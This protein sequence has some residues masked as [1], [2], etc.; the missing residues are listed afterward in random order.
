MRKK[1]N[2]KLKETQKNNGI[3]DDRISIGE[4]RKIWDDDD[5]KYTDKELLKIRG[6]FYVLAEV[7]LKIYYDPN[8]EKLINGYKKWKH[9]RKESNIVC[10]GEYRRAS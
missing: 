10:E 3:F 5:I 8:Y 6:W 1:L 9:E 4:V 2:V 7:V